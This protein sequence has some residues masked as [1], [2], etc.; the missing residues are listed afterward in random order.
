MAAEA[1]YAKLPRIM[2]EEITFGDKNYAGTDYPHADA[3]VISARIGVMKVHRVPIDNGSSMSLLFKSAFDQ[4][5]LSEKD[6]LPCASALQG[7]SGERKEPLGVITLPVELGMEPQRMTRQVQF[8]VLD[9]PSAYNAFLGRPALSDFRAVTA[10]WCLKLKF[11]TPAGVGIVTG[12]QSVSR[13]CYVV[14]L[15]Q[16][17]HLERGKGIFE[18]PCPTK[19][20]G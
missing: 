5:G 6:L 15:R 4:M 10:I 3:L 7:F 20:N 8:V 17:R 18:R 16:M 19:A 13:E 1:G 14:E 2:T 11:P 12:N 9:S